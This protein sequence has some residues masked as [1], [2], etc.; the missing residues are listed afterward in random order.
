MATEDRKIDLTSSS[1]NPGEREHFLAAQSATRTSAGSA[2]GTHGA[3]TVAYGA[4]AARAGLEALKQGGSAVDAAMSTALAQVALTA[5]A[6]ISYFGIMSL[7]YHDAKTRQT[8]TMN[9]EWNTVSGETDPLS[10]PGSIAFGDEKSLLGLGEPSGRTALVGG[11]MKGV[12]AAHA[13]FGKLPFSSL[14]QPAIEIAENG[15]PVN[16]SLGW[17]YG[18]RKDDLARLPATRDALLKPDGS[19]YR[20]GEIL[21]QPMLAETLRR[22][23]DEGAGYMYGGPWGEKL[24]AALRAE[25]GKMTLD[26]LTDYEVQW[27]EPLMSDLHS[28]YSLATAPWPNGGGVALIEAQNLAEAAGLTAGRHWSHSSDTLRVAL[29]ISQLMILVFL[30]PE[31]LAAIFPDLDF[32]PESRVTKAHAEKLW[33]RIENG[34]PLPSWKRTSPMHSD[35][36]VA[37]D[38]EGNIAAITHSINCVLWGKTAINVDGVSI[39]DPA[40]YQ[41]E[42]IARTGSGKRLPSPTETGILFRDGDPVLGFASMGAGLHQRTFQCLLNYM[43]FGMTVEEAINTP[44]FFL[45]AT[46]AATGEATATFP[47]GR[48]DRALLDGTGLAWQEVEGQEARLGGEGIWIGIERDPDS[49]QLSA[50]S[51][52]RNNSDAVAF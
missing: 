21:C 46:D 45:P 19:P 27:S 52:N 15:A 2:T 11:F 31:T 30:A 41:Q 28:G 44:D 40:S 18:L 14:F 29:D 37:I 22:I 50:G 49:G 47:A 39:G 42:L 33:K 35:D 26:D 24:V 34:S 12:E 43:S 48:F 3:V 13:K 5:G 16:S 10:I 8:H 51:H 17:S 9:A 25:D 20:E 38:A 1:W 36:V 4:Y 7:V 32:S 6:P 23:A